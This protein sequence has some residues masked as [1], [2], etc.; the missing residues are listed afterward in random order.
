L[1]DKSGNLG[2]NALP[3]GALGLSQYQAA[4]ARESLQSQLSK[5]PAASQV[6]PVASKL[7]DQYSTGQINPAQEKQISDW[8]NSQKASVK[9]RYANMG[10][11]PNNDSAAQAEMA[12]IDAS[13]V[14]MRD[15]AQQGVLT[16]GLTAAGVAQGPATNAIMAGYQSDL[17]SQ[18]SMQNFLN[19]LARMQAMQTGTKT[20]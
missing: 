12:N 15:Q 4:K 11:D 17:Q 6:S 13:A 7:L 19:T 18:Q 9:Q 14:A 1:L 20:P 5:T 3:L 16:Q 8:T 2:A 10:R